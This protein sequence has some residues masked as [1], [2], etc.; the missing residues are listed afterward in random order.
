VYDSV[1]QSVAMCGSVL[2]CMAVRGSVR[3]YVAACGS[4]W[5]CVECMAVLQCVVVHDSV[6]RLLCG[7]M[8]R[9]T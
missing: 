6:L 8:C 1:W 4:V 9:V 2:Q 5:Q 3:Y 7:L